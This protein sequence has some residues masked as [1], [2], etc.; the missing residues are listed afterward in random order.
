MELLKICQTGDYMKKYKLEKV[1]N[2]WA[3][4]E[5]RTVEILPNMKDAN[6]IMK[7]LKKEELMSTSISFNSIARR[8]GGLYSTHIVI[9]SDIVRY[10][11]IFPGDVINF[12]LNVVIDKDDEE[13][14]ED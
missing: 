14:E 4:I 1:K 9:P 3:V 2:G 5:I 8:S 10:L 12:S 11:T 13:N 6:K 7:G